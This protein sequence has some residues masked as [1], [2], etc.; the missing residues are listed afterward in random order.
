MWTNTTNIGDIHNRQIA[1]IRKCDILFCG[2]NHLIFVHYKFL[3][4]LNFF[5]QIKSKG[6]LYSVNKI[7]KKI[8]P[9]TINYKSELK[10][11][12]GTPHRYNTDGSTV[13]KFVLRFNLDQKIVGKYQILLF[14]IAKNGETISATREI[15]RGPC[16]RNKVRFIGSWCIH[17]MTD[18][19][20]LLYLLIS[21]TVRMTM[22]SL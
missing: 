16:F 21:Y 1:W 19:T 17:R 3:F 7:T 12:I 22:L 18:Q 6:E 2:K 4:F 10:N 9:K 20:V 11:I 15:E 5:F 8:Q 14:Y 13:D